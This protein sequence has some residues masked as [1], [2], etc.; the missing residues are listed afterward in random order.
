MGE[1]TTAE[2]IAELREWAD[3]ES[4]NPEQLLLL[5]TA[6]RLEAAESSR[7][8]HKQN[9][10]QKFQMWMKAEAKIKAIG[11]RLTLLSLNPYLMPNIRRLVDELEGILKEKE[12]E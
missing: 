2:L 4:G 8:L 3:H 12:N 9:A 5:E 11:D 7:D 1:P 10:Q 6:K